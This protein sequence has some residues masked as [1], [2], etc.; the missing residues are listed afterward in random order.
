MFKFKEKSS[1]EIKKEI[2]IYAIAIVVLSALI[3]FFHPIKTYADGKL[4]IENLAS[5]IVAFD[6][7]DSDGDNMWFTLVFSDVDKGEY[8]VDEIILGTLVRIYELGQAILD[9]FVKIIC[10]T[11]EPT[12]NPLFA[13]ESGTNLTADTAIGLI[14]ENQNAANRWANWTNETVDFN[15]SKTLMT[16]WKFTFPF[17]IIVAT[18]IA[19][20]NLFLCIM[21][22][23]QEIKD[24]PAMIGAK[25]LLALVLI[26]LSREFAAIFINFYGDIWRNLVINGEPLMTACGDSNKWLCFQFVRRA[27]GAM[28][29]VF[30]GMD[31][32]LS[33]GG[34][35]TLLLIIILIIG[36]VLA[37][38]LIK[39]FLKLF[40]EIVERY[41]VF[42]L[43]LAFFPCIAATITSNTTKRIF[44]TYLRMI[45]S[46]GF[47]LII[48]TIFMS[49]FFTILS[50][51]GW[52][53]GLLNYLA[54][55]AF[56]RVCQRADAYMAQMG[57]NV[58]QTGN[59]LI[60]A[61]GGSAMGFGSALHAL[62]MAD[63]GRQNIGKGVQQLG[64]NSN[65]SGVAAMGAM[66]GATM[67][68][69]IGGGLSSD[70]LSQTI[71]KEQSE[72]IK[73][74]QNG[75][76]VGNVSPVS[77][78]DWDGVR[79]QLKEGGMSDSAAGAFVNK[80]QQEGYN[81][82]D[83]GSVTQLDKDARNFAIS[84]T[85][86]NQF[87][88]VH[89]MGSNLLDKN[90]YDA[91]QREINGKIGEG[92]GEGLIDNDPGRAEEAQRA[93]DALMGYAESSGIKQAMM[94]EEAK[95][96][97]EPLSEE[98]M[99][100]IANKDAADKVKD[101]QSKA[102]D[103]AMDDN[104]WEAH[105]ADAKADFDALSQNVEEAAARLDKS[106][107]A[108]NAALDKNE[109]SDGAFSSEVAEAKEAMDESAALKDEADSAFTSKFGEDTFNK[110]FGAD[111]D[112]STRGFSQEAFANYSAGMVTQN[113][114][115]MFDDYKS[116]KFAELQAQNYEYANPT[117]KVETVPINGQPGV[118]NG[119][120]YYGQQTYSDLQV[121]NN[122]SYNK[123]EGDLSV[124]N[125][126][127]SYTIK[128][129]NRKSKD[130]NRTKTK[131][132][133]TV[134]G[135]PKRD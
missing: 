57:F 80:A 128:D 28:G 126:K 88:S 23:M 56:L 111:A 77:A 117:F 62:S 108:Y 72:H 131:S 35:A 17:S 135:K 122:A 44:Y 134:E 99:E 97:Y 96:P 91:A 33:T 95:H 85:N 75:M 40:L 89:G 132:G 73:D 54:A 130:T 59:S 52:T 102:Y 82:T 1:E 119:T 30:W 92:K 37:I 41:F 29:L 42:F 68:D 120:F 123:Q 36:L 103:A 4:D 81:P 114:P 31:I 129:G 55:F 47:L 127:H 27:G 45:M 106:T 26:F 133:K 32:D 110:N 66:M 63:R 13:L 2:L 60:G 10:S 38:K 15:H 84:D 90:E 12:L 105:S 70:T 22:K 61:I 125:G 50:V 104:D 8:I 51:G 25:Y 79:S 9:I 87:A 78:G 101:E 20:F 24:T 76:G 16:I 58:V 118:S 14:D 7:T 71:M 124:S 49:I 98:Q 100:D 83:I 74:V 5:K 65:N 93:S 19:L 34:L 109:N 116:Q 121:L 107:E 43:L 67:G 113:N 94:E 48:N 46:Q 53:A 3:L 18:L 64:V 112:E 39:E 11:F 115:Q 6:N 86:G 69:V 21:G